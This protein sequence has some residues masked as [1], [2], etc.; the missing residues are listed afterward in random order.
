MHN[1]ATKFHY[2]RARELRNNSTHSETVLWVYLRTKPHGLKFRRQHPYAI[3]ILDFYCHS[4]K[5]VIELDGSI[6]NLPENKLYDEKRQMELEEDGL[7]VI[8]FTN[9]QVDKNLESVIKQIELFILSNK[10][11]K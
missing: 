7:T 1:G 9:E 8:R 4:L 10:D 5:L 3:Y 6:H 11:E 2:Q